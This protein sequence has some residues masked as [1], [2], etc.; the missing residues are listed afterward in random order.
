[1]DIDAILQ[2]IHRAYQGDTDYP[3]SG[4]DDYTFRFGLIVDSIRSWSTQGSEENIDWKELFTDLTTA[5]T[6]DKT[7]TS[8]DTTYDAPDDFDHVTSWVTITN[9]S[10]ASIY[11]EVISSDKVTERT[12]ND[13]GGTWCY[14]T[15]NERDGYTLNIPFPIA[16]TINYN[17]YKTAFIPTDGADKPE[18][19][20]PYFIVH[21]VLSKLFELDG[22]NDLVTFHEQ[23]K[24]G[25][26]DSMIIDN[27]TA[28]YGNS[29][30]VQDLQYNAGGVSW[31]K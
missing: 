31:G 16:G 19:K 23:K 5:S 1:M 10:Q 9:G 22:R 26:M 20:R 8:S 30:A 6:G 25:I 24:K 14:F 13:Y 17:Y 28:P 21:D 4:D 11:Y 12:R 29:N 2:A 3:T 27:E 7:A 15:G 18:M